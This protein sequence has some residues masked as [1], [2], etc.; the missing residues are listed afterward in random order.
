MSKVSRR[1]QASGRIYMRYRD[2]DFRIFN[3]NTGKEMPW[4]TVAGFFGN[5]VVKS[6]NPGKPGDKPREGTIK[7]TCADKDIVF[8]EYLVG[9]LASGMKGIVIG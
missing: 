9:A 4:H 5:L 1:G 7:Y 2:F 8:F 3:R 6:N